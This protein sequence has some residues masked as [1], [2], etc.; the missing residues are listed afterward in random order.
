MF[1]QHLSFTY[2]LLSKHLLTYFYYTKGFYLIHLV[3]LIKCFFL[4][5]NKQLVTLPSTRE[6]KPFTSRIKNKHILLVGKDISLIQSLSFWL[7]VGRLSQIVSNK[8]V[9][10]VMSVKGC[11]RKE[12]EYENGKCWANN[13][14][15]WIKILNLL[16]KFQI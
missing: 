10:T 4:V 7:W 8:S 2:S 3:T 16:I 13:L 12:K 14:M 6:A 5:I 1:A 11:T 9:Y 15:F